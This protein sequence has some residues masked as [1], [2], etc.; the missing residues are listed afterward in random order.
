MGSPAVGR[1]IA[2]A[3]FWGCLTLGYVC[4]ELSVGRSTVF[5]FLW[6]A[7]LLGLSYAPYGSALFSPYVAV[8]D[9]ALV[10]LVVKGDVKLT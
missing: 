6:L 2:Q 3:V 7:G 8:L 1:W 5:L 9:I 10:F 4:D